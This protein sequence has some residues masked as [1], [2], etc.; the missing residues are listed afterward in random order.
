MATYFISRHQGAIEWIKQQPQWQ[1]DVF[2]THLDTAQIQAGDVVLG[3]LPLHLA[4]EVCKRGAKFYFLILPQNCDERG[5]EHT[6][7]AMSVAGATLER[8]EVTKITE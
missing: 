1:I 5:N 3:T 6:A 7:A 2:T 8:F 4:A